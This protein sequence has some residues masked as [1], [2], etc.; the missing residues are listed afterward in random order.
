MNQLQRA[1][2]LASLLP[3]VNP[4]V[5]TLQNALN[6]CLPLLCNQTA[7]QN[8]V[9]AV[10]TQL[11]C[12]FGSTGSSGDSAYLDGLLAGINE[13]SAGLANTTKNSKRITVAVV[14]EPRAGVGPTEPLWATTVVRDPNAG[15][16]TAGGQC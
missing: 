1:G 15:L 9:N 2:R 8:A 5:G 7:V 12:I 4:L 10:N 14:V 6:A 3:G 11:N 13:I 16:L